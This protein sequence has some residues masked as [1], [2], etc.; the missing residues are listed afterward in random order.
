MDITRIAI[1]YDGNFLLHSS[2]YYNYIHHVRRRISIGGLQRFLK[3]HISDLIGYDISDCRISES[4]Y[5][6]GRLNATDAASRGNQ[7]YNDRV[8]DDILMS[9]GVQKH[10]LPLRN[11]GSRREESGTN[12]WLSL[13]AYQKAVRGDYD[14]AVLVVADTDYVP[15]LRKLSQLNVKTVVV[16]W[17][18][19]Y[20][21]DEGV[22]MTTRTSHELR[23]IAD[24]S[25]YMTQV[26]ED[27]LMD[28]DP[29][30]NAIFVGGA[31]G[32]L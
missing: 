27:K 25:L 32:T 19:E 5:F 3:S 11:S 12:V 30:A 20:T 8:F 1:F 13:E 9:E 23:S 18:F 2:N 4:H 10:Y 24:I 16:G 6:R 17:D 15:L 7:L 26:I 29:V 31:N 14:V 28:D 22:L 21:T